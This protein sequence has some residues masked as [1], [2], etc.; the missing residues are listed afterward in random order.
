MPGDGD[1]PIVLTFVVPSYNV[2][3]YLGRCLSSLLIEQD[4]SDTEI[5][6]VN[7]GSK[8]GTPA[9]AREYES[10]YPGVIRVIDQTNKGHGGAVNTGVANARGM[11]VKVVDADDWLDMVALRNVLAELRTQAQATAPVDLVVTNYTYEKQGK[12]IKKTVR[13]GS[14]MRPNTILG[15]NEVRRFRPDQNLL[16][17]SLIYR[18]KV[19][20]EKAGL[21]LPEHTFYVDNIYAYAPLPQVRTL[22]YLDEDLYRYFIGR[23]GQ[24]VEE[25]TM[26]RRIDQLIRVVRAMVD[27]T[28]GRDAVPAG[29]YRY[30]IHYL[31]INMA[32]DSVFMVLSKDRENY[33]RKD[34][35]WAYLAERAP[36]ADA[37]VRRTVIGRLLTV[38]GPLG[39]GLIRLGYA[40]A[41]N[42]VGVN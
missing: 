17:H 7:D 26:I 27:A 28:P 37:A 3:D 31:T 12:R 15:W 35:L 1:N 42:V 34:E 6:I 21:R 33:R 18:T 40:I 4:L 24:S 22:M 19:L 32:I 30:M 9:L 38:R 5:I 13:Y 25:E 36:E 8:D 41:H 23:E 10:R 11:Y 29:L 39:R 14:V 2:E 20:R 16:M